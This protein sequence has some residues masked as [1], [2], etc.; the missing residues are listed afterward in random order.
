MCIDML[1]GKDDLVFGEF[2]PRP[3]QFHRFNAEWDRRMGVAWQRAEGR[4]REDLVEGKR[5]DAYTT[6]TKET[7]GS[8]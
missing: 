1:L 8:L 2:T 5:L 3:G 4:L 7:Y 6:V